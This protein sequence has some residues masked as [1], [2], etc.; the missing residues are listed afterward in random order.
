MHILKKHE[1]KYKVK[2]TCTSQTTK[3]FTCNNICKLLVT[4]EH[5]SIKTDL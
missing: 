5:K 3:R 1:Q 4:K 2:E